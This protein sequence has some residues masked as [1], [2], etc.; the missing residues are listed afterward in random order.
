MQGPD[1][2]T[3]YPMPGLPQICFLKSIITRPNIE[4]GDYTYY[5]DPDG[6]KRFEDNDALYAATR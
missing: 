3:P 5:D 4:I 1:P 2:H 6:V